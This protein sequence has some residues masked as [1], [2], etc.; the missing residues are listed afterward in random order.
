M[1]H[2]NECSWG[3]TTNFMDTS[4]V[5]R[6]KVEG[7]KYFLDGEWKDLKIVKE[8]IKVKGQDD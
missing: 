6:E 2:T 4:D 8:I 3:F 1:G 5:W 7:N